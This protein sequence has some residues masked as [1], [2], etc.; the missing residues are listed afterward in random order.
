MRTIGTMVDSGTLRSGGRRLAG[1]SDALRIAV[2]VALLAAL[3]AGCS[4]QPD[5]YSASSQ[6]DVYSAEASGDGLT[7]YLEMA[8]CNGDFTISVE[9]GT[10]DVRVEVT[11]HRR[12][13]PLSGEDCASRA[14]PVVLAEPLGDRRLVDAVHGVDVPVRYWPWNQTVYSDADY[15]AAVKDAAACVE[16]LEPQARVEIVTNESG[17][18]DLDVSMPDLGD[19][20]S[21]TGPDASVICAERHIEPLHH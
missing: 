6:P 3:G 12:R 2:F 4:S 14:G 19:G 15:L 9:D 7:L 10:E 11:D 20:E 17:K 13:S 16:E 18:P 5:F 8:S 1:A 21:S